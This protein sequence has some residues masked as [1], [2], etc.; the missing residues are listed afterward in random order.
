MLYEITLITPE[1]NTAGDMAKIRS[2]VEKWADI[3]TVEDNG[4]KR[5]A[6]AIRFNGVEH[7][8]G[9][10]LFYTA[11]LNDGDPQRLSA[12]LCR[13]NKVLMHLVVKSARNYIKH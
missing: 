8:F 4:V 9:H 7:N 3:H 12:E 2:T 10:Y 1:N 13:D 5:L 11:T 6:Y